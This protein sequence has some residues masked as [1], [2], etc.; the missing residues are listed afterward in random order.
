MWPLLSAAINASVLL[1]SK[2][3]RAGGVSTQRPKGEQQGLF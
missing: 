1:C 2:N 3:V